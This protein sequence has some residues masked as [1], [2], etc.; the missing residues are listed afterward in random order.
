MTQGK[1]ETVAHALA[2]ATQAAART[3]KRTSP[4]LPAE[5][6]RHGTAAST[7]AA[8]H[9]DRPRVVLGA[10]APTCAPASDYGVG[11]G[12][13]SAGV[14]AGGLDLGIDMTGTIGAATEPR[15]APIAWSSISQ[16]PHPHVH[17]S[18]EPAYEPGPVERK[19]WARAA[20]K[21]GIRV[22]VED[23]GVALQCNGIGS[24]GWSASASAVGMASR[25]RVSSRFVDADGLPGPRV[26]EAV[27]M[28]WK[29]ATAGWDAKKKK[30]K[31]ESESSAKGGASTS[32]V[33]GGGAGSVDDGRRAPR[34]PQL[35][36]TRG[37]ADKTPLKL[38]LNPTH[39]DKLRNLYARG[40]GA[41]QPEL[42]MPRLYAMLARYEALS[43]GGGGF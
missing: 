22:S 13:T 16:P 9:S 39:Y 10:P 17:A 23:S 40:P 42:F 7:L 12:V 25:A 34:P 38:R 8:W 32:M 14:T 6:V 4:A 36:V 15:P 41:A 28:S 1:A 18:P 26:P 35:L 29:E 19:E 30:I 24:V 5:L 33:S 21:A 27:W 37:P 2:R 31:S 20:T 11:L 43:A 3:V